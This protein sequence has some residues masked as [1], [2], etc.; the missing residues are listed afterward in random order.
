MLLKGF[1][2]EMDNKQYTI[3]EKNEKIS[4]DDLCCMIQTAHQEN[5]RHGIKVNTKI[6][7]G[8]LL[9]EHLGDAT[10]FVA[11]HGDEAI[12]TISCE[13]KIEHIPCV[14]EIKTGFLSFLAVLP[15][16]NGYGVCTALMKASWAYAEAHN[17]KAVDLLVVEN[18]PA[19]QIYKHYGFKPV[20]YI[21]RKSSNQF[22]I[23]FIKWL[24]EPPKSAGL[25]KVR[26]WVKRALVRCKVALVK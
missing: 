13:T 1:L 22:S 17:A 10:T 26:F 5:R 25:I 14:G 11:M 4:Y 9:K 18:N 6:T 2:E 16:W 8:T 20:N 3:I 19:S 23:H 12:G 24:T 21:Y 7:T 15:D